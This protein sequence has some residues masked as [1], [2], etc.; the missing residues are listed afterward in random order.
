M[1]PRE[2]VSRRSRVPST[3]AA[4][5]V[6]IA[7]NMSTPWWERPPERGAPQVSVNETGPFTGQDPFF[8]PTGTGVAPASLAVAGLGE[9]RALTAPEGVGT[10][11]T[12]AAAVFLAASALALAAAASFAAFSRSALRAASRSDASLASSVWALVKL[13]VKDLVCVDMPASR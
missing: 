11:I 5:G 12:A 10:A 7:A 2:L 6:L 1:P 13:S 3:M 9:A 4:A 8:V